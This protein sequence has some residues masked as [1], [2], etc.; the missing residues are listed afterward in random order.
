[1]FVVLVPLLLQGWVVV[2]TPLAS[3]RTTRLQVDLEPGQVLRADTGSLLYMTE[4]VEIETSL[5][6]GLSA[7]MKRYMTGQGAFITDY[8]FTGD[9]GHGTVCLGTE[10]PS[11]ILKLSLAD[12]GGSLI[13][14]KGAF[15]AANS[16][17]GIEMEMARSLKAGFFGG[18]G[19]VL[20]RLTGEGDVFVKAGG[21]LI[22]RELE[23]GEVRKGLGFGGLMPVLHVPRADP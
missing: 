16:T 14:Q 13:C 12:H 3:S 8:R 1:M 11:K 23:P 7:G 17:V 20:Q 5:G 21:A 10:Y 2:S 15:M 18:E 6:G 4:G 22:R 9:A 19:F